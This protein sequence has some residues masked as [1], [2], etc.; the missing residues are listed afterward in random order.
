MSRSLEII[1][2]E[3][4]TKVTKGGTTLNAMIQEPLLYSLVIIVFGNARVCYNLFNENKV[5]KFANFFSKSKSSDISLTGCNYCMRKANVYKI[6]KARKYDVPKGY[7]KRIL[8]GPR[9]D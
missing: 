7:L 3:E 5:K 6:Y 9:K 8:K 4:V 2:R 1:L